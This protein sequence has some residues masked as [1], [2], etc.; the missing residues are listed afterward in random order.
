MKSPY[1]RTYRVSQ[2]YK[3][4]VHKGMD[5]VGVT[6][7]NIFSPVGGVV[8][9]SGR[10]INPRNPMD[11][12][13]GMGNYIRIRDSVTGYRHY[14]AHLSKLIA[15]VGQTVK[16][17]DLIGVEG[18]TGHSFGSHLHY[19]VRRTTDNTTYMDTSKMIGIPN[20][21]GTY[22]QEEEGDDEVVT[23][24]TVE[25]NG[26]KK[27]VEAINKDGINYVKLRD[28]DDFFNIE[29]DP[30]RKIPVLSEK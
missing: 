29:W 12:R 8:E 27:Q 11:L 19:E 17:G 5:L 25:I 23:M 2:R 28:L 26:V 1:K 13:Y 16:P 30:I 7:K 4:S 18:N 24:L 20:Q 10:D 9:R 22:Y 14:F 15:K 3:G 6:S 21:E